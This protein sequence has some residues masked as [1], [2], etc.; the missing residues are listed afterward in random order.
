M[1]EYIKGILVHIDN[2]TAVVDVNGIGYKL[3]IPSSDAS[4]A[5]LDKEVFFHVSHVVKEDRQWLYGFLTKENKVLFE[6][7]IQMSGIGPKTALALISHLGADQFY[8]C[9]ASQD[10]RLISKVPG[11]GKKTA[12]RLLLDM[13]DKLKAMPKSSFIQTDT[14]NSNSHL[15]DAIYAL[16]NLGYHPLQ[17]KKAV[18]AAYEKNSEADTATLISNA[19]S[20]S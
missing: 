14:A 4:N 16:I 2:T 9:I 1:Y 15:T 11:I 20:T 17:A 13:K 19:L 6:T 5:Q 3:H 10:P 18:Q 8:E 12:E 7:L